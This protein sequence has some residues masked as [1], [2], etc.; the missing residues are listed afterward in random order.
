MILCRLTDI[1][2]KFNLDSNKIKFV[3][4][5]LSYK[6]PNPCGNYLFD[7]EGDKSW[8]IATTVFIFTPMV[9]SFFIGLIKDHRKCRQYERLRVKGS[10]CIEIDRLP[11]SRM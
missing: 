8:F 1:T 3:T 2:R 11:N 6:L 5:F 4:R 7:S 10:M 9:V